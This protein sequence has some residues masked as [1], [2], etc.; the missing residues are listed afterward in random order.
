MKPLI[1]P[2]IVSILGFV[3]FAASQPLL[4]GLMEKIITAIEQKDSQAQWVLPLYALGIFV[5]RGIGTFLGTYFLSYVTGKLVMSLQKEVFNHITA[6]PASYFDSNAQGQ[7]IARITSSVGMVTGAVTEAVKIVIREGLTVIFLLAYAFYLNWQLSL[8]FIVVTPVIML[9]I[10]Y[11]SKRF[12][13]ITKKAQLIAGDVMQT[14]REML[15]GYQVMR[16]FGGEEYE[17]ERFS[18][19][20]YEG[21]R[22][23]MKSAKIAAISV[24]TMQ[25]LV[26]MALAA[27]IF[28]ILQP[29]ILQNSTTGELVGYL[30]AIALLPKPIKQLTMINPT[31]QAGIS[32]GE[33]VFNVL[34]TPAEVD[35]GTIDNK[36]IAGDIRFENVTFSYGVKNETVLHDIS[37][38]IKAGQT[39]A[40]VGRSGS[41]KTT[42]ANLLPR[43]YDVSQG[44]ITLDGVNIQDYT[45][46][47]LRKHIALVNQNVVLFNDTIRRNI[48]YGGLQNISEENM[49]DAAEK[50]YATE[51]INNQPEGLETVIGESGLQ[52]SG[53]QRQRLSIARALLKDAPVLILDEATSALDNESEQKIQE[54]LKTVMQGR[55]TLVIAHRLST[56]ENADNILVMEHGRIVEQGKHEELLA[57]NG[58][59]SKLHS[60]GFDSMDV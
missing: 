52:L 44:K 34:D 31:I 18:K 10:S 30:T 28:L 55:S 16:I 38:E 39:V 8:M 43:F 60:L 35:N 24:P 57:L 7:L 9:I 14:I 29:A 45:L 36:S 50:A 12:R 53:G 58:V 11:T 54:A 21:F 6:L 37:F 42:I 13:T 22:Q 59:Y 51:F 49:L 32:G 3:I 46:A 47:Y 2:F 40:L 1:V 19:D 33:M 5:V 23:G 4:P 15:N 48:A 41:G 27:V 56:I 17:R 20:L 25:L 26:A